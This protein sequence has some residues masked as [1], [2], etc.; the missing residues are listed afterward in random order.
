M[1][2]RSSSPVVLSKCSD[3]KRR[4]LTYYVIGVLGGARHVV[5]VCATATVADKLVVVVYHAKSQKGLCQLNSVYDN[6]LLC[7]DR[8][9]SHTPLPR[10]KG[11]EWY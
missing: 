1:V 6:L 10:T 4:V 7:I 5:L 8:K 9:C 3:S 2:A 11:L